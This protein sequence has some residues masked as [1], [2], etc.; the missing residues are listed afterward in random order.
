MNIPLT[1]MLCALLSLL[2]IS[3]SAKN[4]GGSNNTLDNKLRSFLKKLFALVSL[5]FCCWGED[6]SMIFLRSTA[7]KFIKRKS[8][9]RLDYIL[10]DP[11]Q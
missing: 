1:T 9:A 11:I 6:Y 7:N 10:A 4:N 3:C 8:C 2:M 5:L